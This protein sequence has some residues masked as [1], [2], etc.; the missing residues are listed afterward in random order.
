MREVAAREGGERTHRLFDAVRAGDVD[1]ARALLAAGGDARLGDGRERLLHAAARRG[2]LAIVELLI[3]SGALEW[4]PDAKGRIPLDIARRGRA[5]DR[6]AIVK[7]LD[8]PSTSDPSFRAAIDA[9]H[10]GDVAVL[11]RLLDAEPRLLHERILEPDA[12]RAAKRHQY[13]LDP[14]LFWFVANNPTLMKRMPANIVDVARAM[15]ARGVEQAD[16]TY[17]LELVMTSL[18]ARE[19]GHQGPLIRVLLDAG[20]QASTQG[21]AVT[22]AHHELDALRELLRAGYPT[23]LG[24]AAA[25]GDVAALRAHLRDAGA[26]RGANGVRARRDQPRGRRPRKHCST[27]APTSTRTSPSTRTA[28]RCIKQR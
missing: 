9:I 26:R 8:R 24:I 28:R 12:Y 27:R 20:A 19:Q 21:I 23:T 11:E 10:R 15:I 3:A 2:P 18:P 6:A 14:K 13:F 4:E 1:A 7:L 25:L 22:A 17:A 5:R 16:L